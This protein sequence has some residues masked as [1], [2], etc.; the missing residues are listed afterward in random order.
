MF[1]FNCCY[2]H[3]IP[4]DELILNI[5]PLPP[6]KVTVSFESHPEYN[7]F[8]IDYPN[9]ESFEEYLKYTKKYANETNS[10]NVPPEL[11]KFMKPNKDDTK[12]IK[13]KIKTLSDIKY[14]NNLG[15]I[16]FH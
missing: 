8:K 11:R 15:E 13:S 6:T 2:T 10:F 9:T 1:L 7:Q 3:N 12:I 14:Q 16:R 5:I 4:K